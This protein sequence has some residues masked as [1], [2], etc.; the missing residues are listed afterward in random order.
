M[1]GYLICLLL[2]LFCLLEMLNERDGVWQSGKEKTCDTTKKKKKEKTKNDTDLK[3][4]E[5]K[6]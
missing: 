5:V 1:P 6:I 2:L 4:K 3:N